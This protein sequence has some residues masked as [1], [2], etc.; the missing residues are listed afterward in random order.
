M[1]KLLIVDDSDSLR[2][3]LKKIL[4]SKGHQVIEGVDGQHG[5]DTLKANKD[6][7]LIIC[8]V[9]MPNMDGVTMCTKVSEDSSIN[10]IPIFMLTT[11]SNADMKEKGKK[12]G[13]KAWITKPFDEA[14]LLLAI[15]KMLS[16]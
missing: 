6:T 9:N 2:Q 3:Q 5:L 8:D 13:V 11:E 15:E 16:T 10:T 7:K 1:A 14:K 12:V 4:E